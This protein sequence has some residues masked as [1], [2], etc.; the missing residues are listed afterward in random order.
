MASDLKMCGPDD[1]QLVTHIVICA[2]H[3][4]LD[5]SVGEQKVYWKSK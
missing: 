1:G 4:L 3:V 5:I 2:K